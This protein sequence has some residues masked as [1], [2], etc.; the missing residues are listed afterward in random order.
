MK[1]GSKTERDQR[2]GDFNLRESIR[3]RERERERYLRETMRS[4]ERERGIEIERSGR[5]RA[6]PHFTGLLLFYVL[7]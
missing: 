4:W 6:R 5:G 7:Y 3:S 1:F 2:K